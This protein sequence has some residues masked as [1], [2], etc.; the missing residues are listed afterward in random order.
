MAYMVEKLASIKATET[1]KENPTEW[2]FD[3][4][5]DKDGFISRVNARAI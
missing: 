4:E 5:R 3:I 2:E 1:E